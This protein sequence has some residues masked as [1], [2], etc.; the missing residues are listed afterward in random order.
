M[1]ARC[2]Q[3]KNLLLI[4]VFFF[5]ILLFLPH[6]ILE[7]DQGIPRQGDFLKDRYLARLLSQKHLQHS[8]SF[9]ITFPKH[10]ASFMKGTL[11]HGHRGC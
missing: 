3:H 9:R 1:R 2:M 5:F 11:I 8:N 7:T 4:L 6:L 10:Y